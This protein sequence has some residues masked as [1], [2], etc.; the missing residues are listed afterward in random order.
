MGGNPMIR[1]HDII[2]QYE[3]RYLEKYAYELNA[4]R[5][6]ALNAFKACRNRYSAQMKL[7][8]EQCQHIAYLPHSCG[9]RNCPHCQAFESQQ[10]IE[11]QQSKLLP[12][13][14]Y[15][16]TFTLPSQWRSLAKAHPKTLYTHLIQNAWETLN[17]FTQ[18]DKNLQGKSGAIMVLH[19][20]NR[21]L[22][23]HPH[24]HCIMPAGALSNDKHQWREKT[25]HYLFNHKALA[26]VFRAKMLA[27]LNKSGHP[28]REG[29]P[30]KWIVDC[31]KVGKG[32]KAIIYLGR[33]LY[34]GVIQ[35]KDIL[36]NENG[37]IHFRYKNSKT[38]KIEIRSLSGED[39]IRL[40]LQH[41][42]P[43][44]FRRTRDYGLLHA[45]SKTD[46]ARL[47]IAL[48]MRVKR[49]IK[50]IP[51]PRKAISCTCCQGTMKI[52][53]TRVQAS[54][55]LR[56]STPEPQTFHPQESNM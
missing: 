17:A 15:L 10:W 22:D 6:Q 25:G 21:R 37:H 51:T 20:H 34:R 44:G 32:D 7:Q 50:V 14:Y 11:R 16:I 47:Q 53:T 40:I 31:K 2:E 26:K 1:L 8:C 23:Y 35:E 43:K 54:R 42:L 56:A 38:K 48:R 30:T 4:E 29:A 5:R 36:K 55:F 52:I 33:Y 39:F 13:D 46:I 41:I 19:T 28:Q 27:A 45:N 49:M 18:T 9:H 24:V 12:T 3:V